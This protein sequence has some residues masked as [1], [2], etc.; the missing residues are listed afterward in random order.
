MSVQ[1]RVGRAAEIFRSTRRQIQASIFLV[2]I[3]GAVI[4]YFMVKTILDN[5]IP[6]VFDTDNLQVFF[7]ILFL[8]L[9]SVVLAAFTIIGSLLAIGISSI[10]LITIPANE[11]SA[12]L[13]Y[14]TRAFVEI[15]MFSSINIEKTGLDKNEFLGTGTDPLAP[16]AYLLN[17]PQREIY[18]TAFVNGTLYFALI[19]MVIAGINFLFKGNTTQAISSFLLSQFI[20][21]YGYMK[22]RIVGLT[23]QTGTVSALI[24]SSMF[25][26]GFMTYLFLEYSL[27]TSYL[28][29]IASP[30]LARQTRVQ[31]QIERLEKFKLG[32]TTEETEKP[33]VKVEEKEPEEEEKLSSELSAGSAG[34]TTAK[35]FGAEAL[36]FLLE[37]AHDSMLARPEGEQQ[38][39]TVRLQRYYEALLAHDRKL[40]YKLGGTSGK[41]FNPIFTLFYVILSSTIRL[42]GIIFLTWLI[43][44]PTIFYESINFPPTLVNS[45]EFDQPEGLLL[46]MIPLVFLILGISMFL[47]KILNFSRASEELIIQEHE[48]QDIIK[49]GKAISSREEYEKMMKEQAPQE[50]KTEKKV[51]TAP[52]R[53]KRKRRRKK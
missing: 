25:Q 6:G 49:K 36:M 15:I 14:V 12:E 52:K 45:I 2:R 29:S 9:F 19:L 30:N 13:V 33:K 16:L 46:V 26:I 22:E 40:P 23:L 11:L 31:K 44:N 20:I 1:E 8:I 37:S 7:L 24:N 10:P 42:T 34:S 51:E 18:N 41:T 38:R 50:Q 5:A 4:L 3:L 27:Q 47:I 48:I 53:R 21:G 35:K 32:I 43:I 39:L 28:S 17:K